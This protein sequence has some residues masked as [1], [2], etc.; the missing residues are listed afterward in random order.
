MISI[1]DDEVRTLREVQ[2]ACEGSAR[3]GGSGWTTTRRLS[4]TRRQR[5]SSR[6]QTLRKLGLLEGIKSEGCAQAQ[7]LWRLTDAGRE[8]CRAALNERGQGG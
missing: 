6:L 8:M 4:G 5:S 1:N 7:W 2:A 3:F